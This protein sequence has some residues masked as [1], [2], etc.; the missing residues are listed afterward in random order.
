M[1]DEITWTAELP[2]VFRRHSGDDLGVIEAAMVSTGSDEEIEK[3]TPEKIKGLINYLMKMRHGSPFEHNSLTFRISAP[4]FVW[5]EFMRHRIASYN[6]QSA[7]YMQME[8][9]FY[10]Y[11]VIRPLVQ[12]GSSAHPDIQHGDMT[13]HSIV[14]TEVEHANRVAWESYQNMITAGAALEAARAVL[15]VNIYSSAYVTMNARALMNFLSLR[16]AS[17]DAIYKT[18]P[19]WEI[20]RV[21]DQMEAEFARLFPI[22]HEAFVRNGRVAP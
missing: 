13:L 8:P 7:R 17:D 3:L 5:R 4:I 21:A 10:N 9:K 20:N 11:P 18:H 22:T 2:V 1:T 14:T 15:P 6:E 12:K 19:Q 16:V